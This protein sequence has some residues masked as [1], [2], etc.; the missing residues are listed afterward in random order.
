M[1]RSL[2]GAADRACRSI[3]LATHNGQQALEVL[4]HGLHAQARDAGVPVW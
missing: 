4:P 3:F 2:H 1:T